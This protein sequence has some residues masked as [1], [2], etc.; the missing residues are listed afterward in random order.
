MIEVNSVRK[1]FNDR[2]KIALDNVSFSAER[3]E[4]ICFLGRNGAGKS[5]LFKI[6]CG[7]MMADEGKVY[8]ENETGR[9]DNVGYLPEVRGLNPKQDV[10][11]HLC[12]ILCYKGIR[13]KEANK[14]VEKWLTRFGMFQY[15]EARID[16]LSKGNQQKIQFI[17]A[18]A[19]EPN[20]LILDEPFSGLDVISA[21]FFWDIIRERKANGTT[22]LFSTHDFDNSL[23]Y[24]DKF[25]FLVNGKVVEYGSIEEIQGRNPKVLEIS[26][27][28]MESRY[29][30]IR[31]L[32]PS[33]VFK[34]KKAVIPIADEKEA[35]II[36]ENLG[37]PFCTR[38]VI[39]EQT[40]KE[41]FCQY[42]KEDGEINEKY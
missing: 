18:I 24:C 35:Q 34:K 29:N 30:E 7:V 22:I 1:V 39:R 23:L 21:E 26:F 3:G 36:Y 33:V 32:C 28:N 25:L 31:V 16:T 42:N 4:I 12:D 20:I 10:F 19:N 13:R 40:I 8:I 6:I 5:T 11:L 37:K 41:L 2:K 17:S 27:D 15:K 38:F 9:I 14:M